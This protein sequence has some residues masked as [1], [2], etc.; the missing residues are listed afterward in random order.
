L[1]RTVFEVGSIVVPAKVASVGKIEKMVQAKKVQMALKG[2][3]LVKGISKTKVF[4]K[5]AGIIEKADIVN[6]LNKL[7]FADDI[8]RGIKNVPANVRT[9]I[10]DILEKVNRIPE[11]IGNIEI[12]IRKIR[13]EFQPRRQ[14]QFAADYGPNIQNPNILNSNVKMKIDKEYVKLSEI[15][16]GMP[17]Q[18]KDVP[19]MLENVSDLRKKLGSVYNYNYT[20]IKKYKT[21]NDIIFTGE[22]S[23]GV[24]KRFVL[25]K[26][27]N[28]AD[29]FVEALENGRIIFSEFGCKTEDEFIELINN[30]NKYLEGTSLT[31]RKNSFKNSK[32]AGTV[33][34][35]VINGL[36]AV[37]IEYD[38]LGF[39]IFKGKYLEDSVDISQTSEALTKGLKG[40]TSDGHKKEA[41]KLLKEKYEIEAQNLGK[42]LEQLLIE[43][44]FSKEAIDHIEAGKATIDGFIW[45]HHQT[46]GTMQLVNELVHSKF[47]H[48]GGDALWGR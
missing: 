47:R 10:D 12:P 30:M 16:D 13:F 23:N 7:K 34:T 5:V 36:G 21:N 20:S 4:G 35:S 48:T 44:E 32:L 41:T 43:K 11:T 2:V 1:G 8:I 18:T 9:K 26:G 46:E 27:F 38:K 42:T 29:E 31:G 24:K 33:K 45:H 17:K 37:S 25:P 22:L 15:V 40:M 14:W 19:E 3:D 6:K 39:P 28:N